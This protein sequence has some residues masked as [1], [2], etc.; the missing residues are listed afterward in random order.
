MIF[1]LTIAETLK[2][3]QILSGAILLTKIKSGHIVMNSAQLTQ[4]DFGD[5]M[6]LIIKE[7]KM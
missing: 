7:S 5:G 3:F 2:E 1:D 4:R 6:D